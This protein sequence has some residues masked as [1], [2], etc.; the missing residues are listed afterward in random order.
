MD[1]Q[2]IQRCKW[3]GC[4]AYEVVFGG[5]YC[6]EHKRQYFQGRPPQS[7]K[8]QPF[9]NLSPKPPPPPG[10]P[11]DPATTRPENRG[12]ENG[13]LNNLYSSATSSPTNEK[14]Q[15][16]GKHTARKSTK[17]PLDLGQGYISV[18]TSPVRR[19]SVDTQSTTDSRPVKR[20]RVSGMPNLPEFY[21]RSNSSSFSENGIP[22]SSKRGMFRQSEER[23]YKLSAVD[24][25]ALRPKKK[26]AANESAKAKTYN[27]QRQPYRRESHHG[28]SSQQIPSSSRPPQGSG[29]NGLV[30]PQ[31][32]IIDL[33]RDD[34][35]EPRSQHPKPQFSPKNHVP[36]GTT[37]S[38]QK[39]K[40]PSDE[41]PDLHREPRGF[42]AINHKQFREGPKQPVGVSQAQHG[43]SVEQ[44]SRNLHAQPSPQKAVPKAP[45]VQ[46]ASKPEKE[47]PPEP[48]ISKQMPNIPALNNGLGPVRI[49]TSDTPTRQCNNL[50]PNT[51][52]RQ[53]ANGIRQVSLDE[54]SS[55]PVNPAQGTTEAE[56]IT[57]KNTTKAVV[58]TTPVPDAPM[59][60]WPQ[61]TKVAKPHQ[62]NGTQPPVQDVQDPPVLQPEKSQPPTT[63][64][65]G[66]LSALLG[67]REWKK[68]SPE[69]RR[70]F[71]VSQHDPV[72]FDA[73]IY[74]EN[75]RPFRPG[76]PLFGV[77]SDAL[78]PRPTR[79][80]MHFDY[81]DPRPRYSEQRFEEWYQRKQKEIS[82]RGNRKKNLGKAVKR[83]AQRKRAAP[84]PS[85]NRRRDALPR[86]VRDNPKWLAALDVLERIEAQVRDKGMKRPLR[87]NGVRDKAPT[88][89]HIDLDSDAD[90][91]SI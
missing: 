13:L 34:D 8:T 9:S 70:L 2:Q 10:L 72:A 87:E 41:I 47:S 89:M 88:P 15:L 40:K 37:A 5:I 18:P 50:P 52:E 44:G 21:P 61:P 90:V 17:Q 58:Q 63:I 1:P 74:S 43:S 76:D 73:Q 7:D 84:I 78:P 75:N 28:S 6:Q 31:S 54:K 14:K 49:D 48:P 4:R 64:N 67:D 86:R 23:T 26:E 35:R 46:A 65:Q 57:T 30:H 51:E 20:Q 82:A 3:E 80:A 59:A 69:E 77:A 81:L 66:P 32:L 83:A 71:W 12:N 79:P 45:T 33:T 22:P 68:M 25:F 62:I 38:H 55:A 85:E 56:Q 53:L 27:D 19:P 91:E 16:S 39:P 11:R 29:P 60:P 42:V 24:D 36:N